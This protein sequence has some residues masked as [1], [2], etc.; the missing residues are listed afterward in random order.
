EF[1][2][3]HPLAR[4]VLRYASEQ[5][6][7]P[8]AVSNFQALQGKG[9]EGQVA[10]ETFWA[11]SLRLMVEKGLKSEAFAEEVRRVGEMEGTVVACG[12][13]RE[14]WALVVLAD[15]VRV[16]ARTAIAQL[17]EAGIQKVV[18]LTGDN[19]AT[20]RAVGEHVGVD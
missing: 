9:A 3:E 11:G 13:E 14:A 10:G 8:L 5:G 4:A 20:A 6:I 16:E 12:T 17:R 1:H 18:M 19:E 2:S 7:Q 15:P